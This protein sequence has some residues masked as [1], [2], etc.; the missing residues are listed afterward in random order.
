[1][2][3]AMCASIIA[4]KAGAMRWRPFALGLFRWQRRGDLPPVSHD[5]TLRHMAVDVVWPSRPVNSSGVTSYGEFG[6]GRYFYDDVGRRW[7]NGRAKGLH[8]GGGIECPISGQRFTVN[9]EVQ[10][11]AMDLA[12]HQPCPGLRQA[13]GRDERPLL[14]SRAPPVFSRSRARSPSRSGLA[15]PT[16]P[17]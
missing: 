2:A 10:V 1:M 14:T 5:L 4:S 3:L 16:E 15:L 17:E 8:G 12:S 6:F 9:G 11:H 13:A 7:T